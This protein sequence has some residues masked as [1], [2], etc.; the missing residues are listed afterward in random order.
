MNELRKYKA[1]LL[2]RERVQQRNVLSVK[3]AERP[4]NGN[5]LDIMMDSKVL[6]SIPIHCNS[7]K[8]YYRCPVQYDLNPAAEAINRLFGMPECCEMSFTCGG[9]NVKYEIMQG[10]EARI[11][12]VANYGGKPVRTFKMPI[13]HDFALEIFTLIAKHVPGVF[14]Q[15]SQ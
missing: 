4:S 14:P 12:A 3:Y 11:D 8:N 9:L 2:V 10:S 15:M 6:A 5:T 7:K 13:T 1:L